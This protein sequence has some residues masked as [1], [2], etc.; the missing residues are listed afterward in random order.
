METSKGNEEHLERFVRRENTVGFR[1][2]K[3]KRP[4]G[5]RRSII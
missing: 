2:N 3:A 5:R 1:K 4:E